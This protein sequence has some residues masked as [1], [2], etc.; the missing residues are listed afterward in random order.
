MFCIWSERIAY[1]S[2]LD[3][4]VKGNHYEEC[5]NGGSALCGPGGSFHGELLP[6]DCPKHGQIFFVCFVFWVFF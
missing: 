6:E 1:C 3:W 2:R 4:G 5:K